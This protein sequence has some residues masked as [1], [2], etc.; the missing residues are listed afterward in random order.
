MVDPVTDRLVKLLGWSML[1]GLIKGLSPSECPPQPVP[2][3]LKGLGPGCTV[4]PISPQLAL[5]SMSCVV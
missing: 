2:S 1:V 3:E 5:G 4:D